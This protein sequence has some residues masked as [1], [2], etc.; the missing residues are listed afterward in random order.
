MLIRLRKTALW[1]GLLFGTHVIVSVPGS[2]AQEKSDRKLVKRVE[3]VYPS[4]AGPLHLSGSVKM[5]VQIARDGKV[6]SVRTTGGNP[7]LAAAAEVA[8]KQ[9]RY[10]AASKESSEIVIITFEAL[11]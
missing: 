5:V 10:E 7:V 9:W 4:I 11:K 8:V 6:E 3:P 1:V 2:D